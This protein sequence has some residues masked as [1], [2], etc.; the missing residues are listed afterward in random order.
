MK[1]IIRLMHHATDERVRLKA[2]EMV[3]DRAI[4]RP[5]Q[6]KYVDEQPTELHV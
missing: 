5:A 6:P 3:L 1:E 2:C 4:G